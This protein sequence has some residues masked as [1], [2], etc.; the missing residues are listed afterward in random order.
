MI[1][2][3]QITPN[4][5]EKAS[6]L[7]RFRSTIWNSGS[8][9][10][11]SRRKLLFSISCSRKNVGC[12]SHRIPLNS[13]LAI[14]RKGLYQSYS[15]PTCPGRYSMEMFS[16]R[17]KNYSSDGIKSVPSTLLRGARH[18]HGFARH[19]VFHHCCE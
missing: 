9:R 3:H 13:S 2:G 12:N 15:C 8:T 10:Q 17:G 11:F 7:P 1:P 5:Q 6:S 16:A 14:P 18:L 19:K 4:S